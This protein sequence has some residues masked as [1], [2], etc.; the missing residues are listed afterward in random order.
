MNGETAIDGKDAKTLPFPRSQRLKA[1]VPLAKSVLEA[2]IGPDFNQAIGVAAPDLVMLEHPKPQHLARWPRAAEG[3]RQNGRFG[4]VL[5][6]N[7]FQ[8]RF[9]RHGASYLSAI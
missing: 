1:G 6:S 2:H 5:S 9:Y 3:T 7:S 8:L 4:F